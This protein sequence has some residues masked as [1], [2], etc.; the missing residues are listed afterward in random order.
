MMPIAFSEVQL[1]Q[2]ESIKQKAASKQM[3]DLM[4]RLTD[5]EKYRTLTLQDRKMLL[6]EG[7]A[8]DLVDNLVFVTQ[9]L[10]AEGLG[11]TKEHDKLITGFTYAAFDPSIYACGTIRRHLAGLTQGRCAYCESYLDATTGGHVVHFRPAATFMEQNNIRRSPYFA[12]AYQQNNLVYS[13]YSC[14]EEYKANRFPVTGQRM[15]AVS[16]EQEKNLLVNPYVDNPRDYIRFNPL[17]AEAYPYDV[18]KAFYHDINHI[19]PADVETLLW[20]NPQK[21]P[22]VFNLLNKPTYNEALEDSFK[23]WQLDKNLSSYKGWS[24]IEC[25]GLNR[26]NLLKKRYDYLC[27]LFG[28]YQL[29]QQKQNTQDSQSA[30]VDW[31]TELLNG[32]EYRSLSQDAVNSWLQGDEPSNQEND[33]NSFDNWLNTYSS[34]LSIS[35]SLE[36]TAFPNWLTSSLIYLVLEKELTVSNK[37][38]LVNLSASD[39]L[40]GS[41]NPEKCVFISVD[42]EK[43]KNNVIKVRSQRNVWETSFQELAASR[44]LEIM[45]LFAHNEIWLEGDY[46]PLA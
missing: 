19:A 29:H 30:M 27:Q 14:S 21:I 35:N 18:V 12:L 3:Q 36:H 7:Y 22:D 24:T 10:M 20:R 40:Y 45:S 25:L 1:N 33:Q 34:T 44:P 28:R 6:S 23:Q 2:E 15:P 26:P 41:D 38:R 46:P 9:R 42:W 16:L 5:G 39:Y 13:C 11:S 37:R 43:D 8:R 31:K 32:I 4:E 17:T